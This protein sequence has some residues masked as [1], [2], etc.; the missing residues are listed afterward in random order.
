MQEHVTK[1]YESQKNNK[2]LQ[3]HYLSSESQNEFIELCPNE[4]RQCEVTEVISAKYY[5]I[6]VDATP[7]VAHVEQTTFIFRYLLKADCGNEY[8]IKERF[9]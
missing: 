2:R 9:L 6:I 5:A 3:V 1:V 7:D 4:V 8:K